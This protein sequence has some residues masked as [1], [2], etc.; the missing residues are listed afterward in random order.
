MS[1]KAGER[2]PGE[3]ERIR[4]QLEEPY[5][6]QRISAIREDIERGEDRAGLGE[7]DLLIFL[8]AQQRD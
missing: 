2:D 6:Q 1:E 7:D 4:A 5:V 8:R 3:A